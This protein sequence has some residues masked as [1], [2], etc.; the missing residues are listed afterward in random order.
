M[1]PS[2]GTRQGLTSDA[3]SSVIPLT[4]ATSVE[5]TSRPV[6]GT[7]HSPAHITSSYATGGIL[8]LSSPKLNCPTAK[9]AP[10]VEHTPS[11]RARL[12]DR[13]HS[14]DLTR[15]TGSSNWDGDEEKRRLKQA[16]AGKSLRDTYSPSRRTD[17]SSENIK[18]LMNS[19]SDKSQIIERS[20]SLPHLIHCIATFDSTTLSLSRQKQTISRLQ[21]ECR[22]KDTQLLLM[23]GAEGIIVSVTLTLTVAAAM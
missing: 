4:S 3:S 12:H 5:H 15:H 7:L 20:D 1:Y 22:E 23:R 2:T 21:Q 13:T 9:V 17:L 8:S 10:M 16:V 6:T 19:L 11:R 14:P 18:S